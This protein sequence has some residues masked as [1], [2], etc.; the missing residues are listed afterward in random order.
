MLEVYM[1]RNNFPNSKK[2]FVFRSRNQRIYT[3]EELVKMIAEYNSTVTEIDALAVMKAFEAVFN[4]LIENGDGV[5]L[6]MGT[7][8]SGA[9]GSASSIDEFFSPKPKTDKRTPKKDHKIS[10][11]FEPAASYAK[12]LLLMPF[13]YLGLEKFCSIMMTSV[14]NASS[15]DSPLYRAGDFVEI[16]GS[17]IKINPKCEEEG[18]FI[19]NSDH[20]FRLDQYLKATRFTIIAHIPDTV[21]RGEYQLFIESAKG[22]S[23]NQ[24]LIDIA[25]RQK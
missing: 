22:T 4:R 2:P 23:S 24:Y 25:K 15:P 17:F 12:N 20:K 5:K 16:K 7:F 18:V 19:M 6:F 13:K 1:T 9:S 21:P 11:L 8:R 14:K 10:L 3:Q